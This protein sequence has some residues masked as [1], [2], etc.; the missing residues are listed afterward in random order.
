MTILFTIDLP[1]LLPTLHKNN[2][3]HVNRIDYIPLPKEPPQTQNYPIASFN[4]IPAPEGE[5]GNA[6]PIEAF[7][8]SY[9]SHA[10][11]NPA[12]NQ[13]T[14]K[15][16]PHLI[17]KVQICHNIKICD[18]SWPG[19]SRIKRRF[20]PLLLLSAV[21]PQRGR[22]PSCTLHVRLAQ[23]AIYSYVCI[24]YLSPGEH[25]PVVLFNVFVCCILWEQKLIR[26][27]W[28]F[29][30]YYCCMYTYMTSLAYGE[31][32]GI[33]ACIITSTSLLAL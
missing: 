29:R 28:L 1:P 25:L 16:T 13:G 10:Q 3:P 24:R 8:R 22:E 19:S 30:I 27:Q 31:H 4:S 15:P 9:S 14:Y 21:I 17:S 20:R 32:C 26:V 2:H 11:I 7:A 6:S 5:G 18:K 12:G 23:L 33:H